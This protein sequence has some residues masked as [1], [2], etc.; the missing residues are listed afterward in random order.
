MQSSVTKYSFKATNRVNWIARQPC[1]AL[2]FGANSTE[3]TH[4]L[5][6]YSIYYVY[7]YFTN[8]ATAQIKLMKCF[9]SLNKR[10]SYLN[11]DLSVYSQDLVISQK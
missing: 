8:L 9:F 4:V 3:N 2:P 10:L 11:L 1:N 5:H 7:F 6:R